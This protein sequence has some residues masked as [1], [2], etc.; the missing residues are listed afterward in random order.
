MEDI[1]NI[2]TSHNAIS[3]VQ[4]QIVS[5]DS[6]ENEPIQWKKKPSDDFKVIND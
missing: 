3:F 5:S 4:M 1:C 6:I 2:K